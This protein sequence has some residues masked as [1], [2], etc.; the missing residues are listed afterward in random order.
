MLEEAQVRL[1]VLIVCVSSGVDGSSDCGRSILDL[2]AAFA[3]FEL[4]NT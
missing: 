2:H 1:R 4:E 3:V